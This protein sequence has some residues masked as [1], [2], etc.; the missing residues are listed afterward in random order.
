M[1]LLSV[2]LRRP[3]IVHGAQEID[4][5]RVDGDTFEPITTPNDAKGIYLPT[6]LP[7]ALQEGHGIATVPLNIHLGPGH[8]TALCPLDGNDA[9]DDDG[10]G[11]GKHGP[12]SGYFPTGFVMHHDRY[13]MPLKMS[14]PNRFCAWA[15]LGPPWLRIR[16]Q[17]V[18]HVCGQSLSNGVALQHESE[19]RVIALPHPLPGVAGGRN[20][21]LW[22][23]LVDAVHAV[24]CTPPHTQPPPVDAAPSPA[25]DLAWYLF[26]VMRER[27][28]VLFQYACRVFVRLGLCDASLTTH[29]CALCGPTPVPV[30]VLRVTSVLSGSLKAATS[31]VQRFGKDFP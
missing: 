1:F 23:E 27:V 13:A 24:I 11:H 30:S 20:R 21:A 25:H 26:E 2:L 14:Y 5:G 17:P 12:V 15:D 9:E 6:C 7:T 8:F 18:L 29:S 31:T 28:I 22:Q 10:D 19:M 16:R 4:D 3:I